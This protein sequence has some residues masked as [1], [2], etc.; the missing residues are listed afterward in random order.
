M[1]KDRSG[2]A[3]L[4]AVCVAVLCAGWRSA[5]AEDAK[6]PTKIEPWKAEDVIFTEEASQPR[7]SPDA[8]WV[9]WVKSSGDKEK[10]ARVSN[11]FL[12]SLTEDRE[13]QL[14]RGTNNNSQP[15][16]SPDGE[17]IAF[18]STKPLPAPKPEL[19]PVQI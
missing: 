17:T 15:R 4:V 9:V 18:L 3:A 16:W 10:D 1:K 13:I 8:K 14:T 19:A 11:L 12:S 6:P 7:I 5:H 2:L